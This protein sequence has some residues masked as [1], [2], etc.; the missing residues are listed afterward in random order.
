MPGL[1][2]LP[3]GLEAYNYRLREY[4]TTKRTAEEIHETGLRMVAEI[5]GQ[6]DVLL[7]QLGRTEGSVR[8]RLDKLRNDQPTFPATAQGRAEYRAQ[9]DRLRSRRRKAG[10]AIV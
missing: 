3:H 10:R 6:M 8:A 4:T 1:W 5:E 7:R 2:S 9:I